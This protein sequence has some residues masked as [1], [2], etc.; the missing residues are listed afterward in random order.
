MFQPP[1]GY[2]WL[3]NIALLPELSHPGWEGLLL[4]SFSNLWVASQ[5]PVATSALLPLSTTESRELTIQAQTKPFCCQYPGV[6]RRTLPG[7]ECEQCPQETVPE[8]QEGSSAEQP[9]VLPDC[10]AGGPHLL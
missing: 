8:A 6:P 10:R 1:T 7:R 3:L 4:L 5:A 9:A 2:H